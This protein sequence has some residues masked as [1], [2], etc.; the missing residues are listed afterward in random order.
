MRMM[1]AFKVLL[2]FCLLHLV[3]GN[4]NLGIYKL[5]LSSAMIIASYPIVKTQTCKQDYALWES[6]GEDIY[7]SDK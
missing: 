7:C 1:E 3:T 2:C 4:I 5:G 6:F